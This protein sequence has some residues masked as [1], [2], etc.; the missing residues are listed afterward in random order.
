MANGDE[1]LGKIHAWLELASSPG[2]CNRAIE[3]CKIEKLRKHTAMPQGFFRRGT[4]DGWQSDLSGSA[5]RTIEYIA[6]EEMQRYG[7]ATQH[8]K[9]HKKPLRLSLYELAQTVVTA[10]ARKAL[11]QG[12]RRRL[13]G[14]ERTVQLMRDFQLV[15]Y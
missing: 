4:S 15:R 5:L 11:F 7:Y 9:A 1:E 8:P 2:E 3:S 12:T 10:P 6:R 13:R 14:L